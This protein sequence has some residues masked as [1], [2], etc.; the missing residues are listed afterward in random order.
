MYLN[1]SNNVLI[2]E[3]DFT[4]F[5]VPEAEKELARFLK[6]NSPDKITM[7][8]L[9]GILSIDSAGVSFLDELHLHYGEQSGI[10]L[11][12]GARPEV[13]ALINTFSTIKLAAVAPDRPMGFFEKIGDD[14]INSYHSLVEALTLAS[15]IFYYSATGLFNRKGQRKGSTIQQ[16]VLLGSQALP[17]VAL[18]SFIIGFILSLQSGVQLRDFGVG[19]FL[20]DLLAITM[21]REMGPLITS[22]IVAGRSGSA[23]ASEIATMQ[24]TEE[25]DALRMMALH[26]IRFVVVPKFHAITIVMPILVMFSILVAE[27]AGAGIAVTL[28]D[29]SIETFVNRSLE[30]LTIKDVIVSFGKSIWFAWV[31]VI[32]GSF[33]GFQVRGGAEGVGQATTASVVSSIF[34]V[35]LFDAIFSLL[36]L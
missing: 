23:I 11:F 18:L 21:V 15:E 36:Y 7:I 1:L 6:D 33:Y 3:G 16:A 27:L 25:L 31:I 30:I 4:K 22:I 28:L 29:T 10:L 8:D 2:L 20:A 9:A 32:I 17:I 12:K 13:Q 26:P 24:V 14:A 34:A 5:T 19:V 35:I